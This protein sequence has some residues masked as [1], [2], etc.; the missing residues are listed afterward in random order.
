MTAERSHVELLVARY[1]NG[2]SVKEIERQ[3]GLAVGSLGNFLRPSRGKG[4]PQ[5]RVM[6]RFA[7][8]LNAPMSEVSEA[9]VRDAGLGGFD[10]TEDEQDLIRRYRKLSDRDQIRLLRVMATFEDTA[11]E[12]SP[13]DNAQHSRPATS[14]NR[15]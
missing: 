1:A 13:D 10:Y 4:L 11:D 2:R 12:A 5:L 3:N 6:Q 15:Q 7:A 9:F 8:A 14:E